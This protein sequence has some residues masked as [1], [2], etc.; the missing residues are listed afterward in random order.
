MVYF[1]LQDKNL[2]FELLWIHRRFR[3]HHHRH[4]LHRRLRHR[5]LLLRVLRSVLKCILCEC[6]VFSRSLKST[7]CQVM[8]GLNLGQITQILR[9]QVQKAAADTS[10]TSDTSDKSDKSDELIVFDRRNGVQDLFF[11]FRWNKMSR[12]MILNEFCDQKI[13]IVSVCYLCTFQLPRR[14]T[15]AGAHL[16]WLRLGMCGVV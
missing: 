1:E 16:P 13:I 15:G 5:L 3:L 6:T 11:M 10:D 4:L 8:P 12:T 14:P 2:E 9:L 7:F